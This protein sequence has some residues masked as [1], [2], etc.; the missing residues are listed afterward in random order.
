MTC[1]SMMRPRVQVAP[2]LQVI[3]C[4]EEPLR[5]ARVSAAEACLPPLPDEAVLHLLYVSAPKVRCS[6]PCS[7]P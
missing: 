2:Q 5:M 7:D 3:V 1:L 4:R 6:R